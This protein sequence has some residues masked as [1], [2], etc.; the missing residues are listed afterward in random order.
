MTD[1]ISVLPLADCLSLVIDHRGK[2]PKKMNTNWANSGYR[3]ISANNVKFSGL[4]KEDSIRFLDEKTYRAWMRE[5]IQRGDLLLTSE[6]PAGQAIYWD[7]DEK[8]VVG[9]RLFCLRTNELA[10]SKY[11][12]YYLQSPTGQFEIYKY[13]SGST[14]FGISAKMFDQ[15]MVRLPD[16]TTQIKVGEFLYQIDKKIETNK[17]IISYL[18]ELA[19]TIFDYWFNQFNFPSEVN[20]P[21]KSNGG[22]MKLDGFVGREIP[23][24]WASGYLRD[25]IKIERGISYK[26][27]EIS[28]Q[29]VP[30]IN[31]NSFYLT[32]AYKAD[33]IKF[34]N[35]L[36]NNNKKLIPGDLVISTTDVTRNAY[37][38]G[39][40]F[41]LPDIF[42]SDVI[43]SCD[44]AKV[45][46]NPTL[47]ASYLD[48]IF[49]SPEY[50]NYIKGFAS[51]TLVL[52]LD[53]KGIEW[54]KIIIPEK[55]VLDRFSKAKMEFEN[56]KSLAIKENLDLNN[57]RDWLLPLLISGQASVK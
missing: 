10:D 8:I 27:S 38:I 44:V 52:H 54:Y 18:D 56:K 26:S 11:L 12:K 21:Y 28:D 22:K 40:S 4:V 24:G 9:Q 31:L 49:N 30:L 47:D 29:G 53:T 16:M 5:E 3:T 42:N 32:G 50:H 7:T 19:K 46:V 20:Q 34:F 33:G 25:Y 13:S 48:M 35:G 23:E 43:A 37:I 2:T 41:L 36:V 1:N 55:R 14:V 6:A 57:L 15:I 39:K 45:V 17:K 51:G